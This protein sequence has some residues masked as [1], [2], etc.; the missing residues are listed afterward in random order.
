MIKLTRIRY[1]CKAIWCYPLDV[2]FHLGLWSYHHR[3]VESAIRDTPGKVFLNKMLYISNFN[4][5]CSWGFER[6][7]ISK[8]L[9]DSGALAW[10]AIIPILFVFVSK[11]YMSTLLRTLSPTVFPPTIIICWDGLFMRLHVCAYLFV[12]ISGPWVHCLSSRFR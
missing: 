2:R 4:I 12:L 1:R 5:I 9:V 8:S 11:S 7:S 10:K 3:W 6:V